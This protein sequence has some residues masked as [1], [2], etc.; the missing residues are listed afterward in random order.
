MKVEVY[1]CALDELN[2]GFNMNYG[3]D[4]NGL[5]HMLSLGFLIFEVNIMRYIKQ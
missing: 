5:F 4:E 1:M 3:E 2:L